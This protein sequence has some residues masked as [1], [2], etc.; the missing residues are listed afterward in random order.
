LSALCTSNPTETEAGL[1]EY[2]VPVAVNEAGSESYVETIV[3]VEELETE[4][5]QT[6]ALIDE[7]VYE[8]YG[9]T[10]EKMEV[11]DDVIRE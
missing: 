2:F 4:I 1:I 8:L 3:R 9:L 11:A 5:K 7:I 6:D 10:D